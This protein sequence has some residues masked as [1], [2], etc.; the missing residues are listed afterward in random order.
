MDASIIFKKYQNLSLFVN[1]GIPFHFLL[2]KVFLALNTTFSF[3][4]LFR[5]YVDEMADCNKISLKFAHLSY[6]TELHPFL[7]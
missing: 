3:T 6:A 2:L 5:K 7:S 1:I 4:K